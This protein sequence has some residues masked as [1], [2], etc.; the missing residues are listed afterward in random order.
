LVNHTRYTAKGFD[1]M[2]RCDKCGQPSVIV[3]GSPI[4]DRR[5]RAD[6]GKNCF[7]WCLDCARL[8]YPNFSAP[9]PKS[10]PKPRQSRTPWFLVYEAAAQQVYE[11]A[12]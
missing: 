8:K 2:R 3:M 6:L 10:K 1:M 4:I 5:V 12:R 11:A 9:Q 7:D